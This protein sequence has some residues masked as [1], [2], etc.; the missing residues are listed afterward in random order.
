MKSIRL[1][2]VVAAAV[3]TGGCVVVALQPVYS[4]DSIVFEERLVGQ[5]ENVED[6]TSAAIDRSEWR[7]Y[8]VAYT[9]RSTTTTFYGNLTQIDKV[10]FLDLTQARGLDSGPYLIPVHGV[11]RI[12]M[13]GDT[14]CASALDYGWFT[15]E[16]ELKKLG[17]LSVALDGRRNVALGAS[18]TELREWLAHAPDEAF[19][20]P[21]TFTRKR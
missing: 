16:L 4:D 15:Q 21:M 14:L 3:L 9:D 18:T 2:A 12:A 19:A 8:R 7:A 1:A 10:L 5:W 6:R 17:R 13:S 11:Y 20:A